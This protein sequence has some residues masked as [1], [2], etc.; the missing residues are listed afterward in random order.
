MV[1]LTQPTSHVTGKPAMVDW[2][3]VAKCKDERA[4]IC[5]CVQLSGLANEEI[6]HQLGIDKGHWTR[7]MQGRG[8]FP[9]H[10]RSQLMSLCGNL[11]PLQFEAMRFGFQLYENQ[12]DKEERECAE[13]L[14]QIRKQKEMMSGV[15]AGLIPHA[16]SS[17]T[18]AFA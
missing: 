8:H 16:V 14:A 1:N 9:T 15:Q 5:L 13:R 4:A 7:I 11:A 17:M 12:L 2:A 6:A 10:K 18:P 3:L